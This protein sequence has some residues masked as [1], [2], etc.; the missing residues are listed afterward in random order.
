MAELYPRQWE[1][2]DM[3]TERLK[4]PGGWIVEVAHV[5]LESISIVYVPDPH[6]EWHLEKRG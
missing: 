2:I 3:D 4:V 1:N 5:A 6:E